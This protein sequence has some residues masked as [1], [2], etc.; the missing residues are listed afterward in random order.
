[1]RTRVTLSVAAIL[2][3]STLLVAGPA[4]AAQAERCTRS[5]DPAKSVARLWDEAILD[6]IRR[7]IPRPT[8]HARN[9][10]HL[11]AGMWDAWAAYDP[12]ADGVFID[13]KVEAEDPAAARDRAISTAAYRILTHRYGQ[14]NGAEE[15]LAEFDALMARSATRSSAPDD[16]AIRRRLSATA[17]PSASSARASRRLERAENYAPATT[18]RSTNRSSWPSR[19]RR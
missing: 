13:E 16:A 9:L 10:Y 4:S 1:M 18:C 14:A 3:A 15:S 2:V 7:D 11:S 12:V 6:A 8:V 19:V 5:G 17:S